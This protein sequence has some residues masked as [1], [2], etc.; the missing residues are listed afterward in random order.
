[1]ILVTGVG[2]ISLLAGCGGS[3]GGDGSADE[4][5]AIDE[6]TLR[7]A[8]SDGGD[9]LTVTLSTA[10]G[11]NSLSL[12]TADGD[13]LGTASVDGSTTIDL[14]TFESGPSDSYE[15]TA[16]DSSGSQIDQ[17]EWQPPSDVAIE[18]V[19]VER[20]EDFRRI[21]IDVRND[22]E[23][24]I[25]ATRAYVTDG[26]PLEVVSDGG[27]EDIV[28]RIAG[29]GSEEELPAGETKTIVMTVD[30]VQSAGSEGRLLNPQSG[31]CPGADE[32]SI[33]VI[34]LTIEFSSEPAKQIQVDVQF[35]GEYRAYYPYG[36]ESVNIAD[37]EEI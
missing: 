2:G 22:A 16:L 24:S 25:T 31:G 36:C 27:N 28:G 21:T 1:M 23:S 8:E 10:D 4:Q 26:F 30:A 11:V 35:G 3:G 15:I 37:W 29:L 6:V 32:E 19:S 33:R 5:A 9:I 17:R 14:Y 20:V 12:A 34:E 18:E 7:S 13:E